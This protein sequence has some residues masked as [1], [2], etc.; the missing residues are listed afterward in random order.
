MKHN[1]NRVVITGMG[2]VSAHGVDNSALWSAISKGSLPLLKTNLDHTES[3]RAVRVDNFQA[4]EFLGKKGLQ[5]MQ[6]CSLYLLVASVLALDTA[7][8]N[9]KNMDSDKLGIVVSTN[10]SGLKMSSQFD[11]TTLIKGPNNVS[12]MQAPNTI[13]NAPASHLAIRINSK[14]FNTTI[15]SGFCAGLD[16]IGYSVSMLRKGAADVV[17][18]GG[19]EEWN[20]QIE[21]YY[22]SAGLLP[23]K[24]FGECGQA[25]NTKSKGIIPGE[26]SAAVVLERY[27][28]AIKR[29]ANILGEVVSHYSCFTPQD[30][31]D[32]RKRGFIR[33]IDTTLQHVYE[34]NNIDLIFSGANGTP[35]KDNIEL[36]TLNATFPDTPVLSIKNT[37]GETS[38]PAGLFQL[39]SS[40]HAINDGT[41]T[42][43]TLLNSYSKKLNN[44]ETALLTENDLSGGTSSVL[45]RKFM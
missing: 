20:D 13:A 31:N 45:V 35:K 6:P 24:Y 40:I 9:I 12:P 10:H 44:I 4:E 3:S 39:V 27:E 36:A 7:S 22:K 26:G 34:N 21:W 41:L 16:G 37:I 17:V 23:N 30:N 38:G 11:K 28:H 15:S 43:H 42:N 32:S 8:I 14:A 1:G 33:C 5:F 2:T 25:F 29:G 19:T 18:V